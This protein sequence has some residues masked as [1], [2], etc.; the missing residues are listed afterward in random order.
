METKQIEV[1][2]PCCATRILID[3]RTGKILR[4]RREEELD[5][6]G[7][8]VVHERDWDDALGRVQGREAT[9]QERLDAALDR[10]KDKA[11]R[12]DELFRKASEKLDEEEDD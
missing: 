12:L 9:Q 8:P 5:E 1:A 4:T 3:V 7:K 6:K 11:D 10:E 2:C